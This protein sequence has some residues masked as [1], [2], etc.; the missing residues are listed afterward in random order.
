MP[1]LFEPFFTT[2]EI[3]KG[4]GLGLATAYGIVRQHH[5]WIEVASQPGAGATFRIL[6]PALETAAVA[7]PAA[8]SEDAKPP[9]GPETILVVEDD[10]TVR[11]LTCRV[12]QN[13]GYKVWSAASGP[14]A[15]EVWRQHAADIDLLLTDVIMPQGIDGRELADQLRAQRP[16]LKVVYMS[17]Y[18]GGLVGQDPNLVWRTHTRFLQKPSPANQLLLTIRQLLDES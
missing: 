16:G 5:G 17:G 18:S 8:R 9:G 13:F 4:T 6:L 7:I 3:G 14:E 15:L 10:N 11:A 2:K 1:R 12:L